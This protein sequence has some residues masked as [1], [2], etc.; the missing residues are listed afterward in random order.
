MNGTEL[1]D[2]IGMGHD[3]SPANVD[4]DRALCKAIDRLTDLARG[5][6]IEIYGKFY[7]SVMVDDRDFHTR[8]ISSEDLS[9]Y[10]QFDTPDTLWRGRGLAWQNDRQDLPAITADHYR[11]VEVKRDDLI[12]FF[13]AGGGQQKRKPKSKPGRKRGS[14]SYFAVDKLLFPEMAS[15]IAEGIA[16]SSQEAARKIAYK[17]RG[18]GTEDSKATRLAKNFRAANPERGN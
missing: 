15:L 18:G 7:E 1:G 9:N 13:D 5:G 17:A 2:W 4:I 8:P 14:G 6:K 3:P 11:E 12:R 16:L 10:R